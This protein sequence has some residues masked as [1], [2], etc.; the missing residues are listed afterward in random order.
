MVGTWAANGPEWMAGSRLVG[1]APAAAAASPSEVVRGCPRHLV[2]RPARSPRSSRS[3][4]VPRRCGVGDLVGGLPEPRMLQDER[5]PLGHRV[6]ISQQAVVSYIRLPYRFVPID[7]VL[8]DELVHHLLQRTP[9]RRDRGRVAEETAVG[10]RSRVH[11]CRRQGTPPAVGRTGRPPGWAT[12]TT[13]TLLG[14]AQLEA[15]AA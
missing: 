14:F 8:V 10:T 7:R 3:W 4:S 1:R 6:R 5:R 13:E 12:G 15:A 11:P 2:R 9:R